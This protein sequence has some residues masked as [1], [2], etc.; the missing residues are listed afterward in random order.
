M[1]ESVKPHTD[2]VVLGMGNLTLLIVGGLLLWGRRGDSSDPSDYYS[3]AD[4][5]ILIR[6]M[7]PIRG[8]VKEKFF[9]NL[10]GGEDR[11]VLH[12]A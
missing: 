5:A 4:F 8:D 1:K 11:G 10:S 3:R 2:I 12:P 6:S 7:S 9:P